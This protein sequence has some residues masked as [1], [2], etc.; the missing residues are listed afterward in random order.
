VTHDATADSL[1]L[2][3]GSGTGRFSLATPPWDAT[4]DDLEPGEDRAAQV[5]IEAAGGQSVASFGSDA[6]GVLTVAAA[7]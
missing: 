5:A 6:G 7:L 3:L 2:A 1:G 4:P